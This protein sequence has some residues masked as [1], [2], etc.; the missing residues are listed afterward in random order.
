MKKLV[1]FTALATILAVS[2]ANAAGFQLREQSAAAQGNAFAGAT[3]G[4]ENPSYAFF[5]VAGLTRQKGIQVNI[6]GTYIAPQAEAKNVSGTGQG[7][8]GE[9]HNIV[10]AAI[11]P[12]GTVSYELDNKTVLGINVSSPFG[13][14]T[15]YNSNWMGSAHGNTSRIHTIAITPMAAYKAT[16][17]LSLGAGFI[18]EK[19]R[20][21]L[22]SKTRGAYDTAVHGDTTDIGYQLGAM[23]EL[24]DNTRFGI[25][26]RSEMKH[27][28]QGEIESS[29]PAPLGVLM[30]QDI[31]CD[32][33]LPATF[34]LGA[35]HKLNDK[36]ELM[37]EYQRTYWSS[38]DRL[39]FNGKDN[40]AFHSRTYE[41]W[42]DT[43]FYALGASYQ[44]DN[45]WKAR[46]GIAFDQAAAK[47]AERTP[48]IPDSDR[49]WYSAGLNYQY[50]DKLSFD[51][52]FTYIKAKDA[53]VDTANTR[54]RGTGPEVYADY[55]NSVKMWGLSLNYKF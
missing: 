21:R 5:N 52:A 51:M 13:M 7:E 47:R 42:R 3:A 15:K 30:N 18:V 8:T 17:K 2:N 12:N 4:A 9:Q 53:V 54:N 16:D 36:W 38:F 49:L 26:Y 20:A 33:D 1:T 41:N 19:V 6:G 23:Y 31:N 11:A 39:D 22:T 28:I 37:A 24:N 34:S 48:R 40:P 10:H 29:I 55:K 43:N 50:N 27:K 32:L 25:G 45:Q 44:I 35:Y 14:I 46:F